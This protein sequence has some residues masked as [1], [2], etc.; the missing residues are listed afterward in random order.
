MGFEVGFEKDVPGY[1]D[2]SEKIG[3]YG[4]QMTMMGRWFGAYISS[5]LPESERLAGWLRESTDSSCRSGATEYE[6]PTWEPTWLEEVIEPAAARVPITDPTLAA[7]VEMFLA[8]S[9][10]TDGV[11]SGD[12]VARLAD[13]FEL[14]SPRLEPD[15][16]WD[17][18]LGRVTRLF[19][20]AAAAGSGIV[21]G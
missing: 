20:A 15:G 11:F 17:V 14:L 18:I 6:A 12:L 5:G 13:A 9:E 4:S 7:L 1:D 19:R 16:F 10:G 8:M 2:L 3:G 21:Y